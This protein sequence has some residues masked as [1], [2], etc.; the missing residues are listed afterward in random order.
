M[1]GIVRYRTKPRQSGIFL[2]RYRTEIIDA[3]M[4]MPALVSSTPMPSYGGWRL[5]KNNPNCHFL[6]GTGSLNQADLSLRAV[7]H[8]YQVILTVASWFGPDTLNINELFSHDS[9]KV[10]SIK[11]S[12]K[13]DW[14]KICLHMG[15]HSSISALIGLA[16][17]TYSY[18][19]LIST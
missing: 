8:H 2:V 13:R 5:Q 14:I 1:P 10:R 19:V 7:R 3:G 4:P 17:S 18:I 12:I 6:S 15:D 16:R 9:G 11:F